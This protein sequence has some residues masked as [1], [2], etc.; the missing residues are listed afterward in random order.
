M[1]IKTHV[2]VYF[3][4]LIK[5][6]EDITNMLT[7][8]VFLKILIFQLSIFKKLLIFIICSVKVIKNH[9]IKSQTVEI[10][11]KMISYL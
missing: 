9:I 5:K 11:R 7:F 2:L 1:A 8:I 10:S 3:Y 4:V 6:I